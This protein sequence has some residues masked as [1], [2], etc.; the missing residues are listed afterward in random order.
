SSQNIK[1]LLCYHK[2]F[3]VKSEI[4][5]HSVPPL[6]KS[7]LDIGILNNKKALP[8]LK[9]VL[10]S[11]YDN[12]NADYIIYSNADIGIMPQFYSAI[13]E[14]IKSGH[15]AIVINRRRIKSTL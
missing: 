1:Q 10:Q 11:A 8:L 9:D 4:P 12:S 15:D 2:N 7:I 3:Q 5:F 14:Y 13:E 6:E